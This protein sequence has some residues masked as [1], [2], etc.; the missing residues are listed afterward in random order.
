MKKWFFY[1]IKYDLKKQRHI[2]KSLKIVKMQLFQNNSEY[3][4]NSMQNT[5]GYF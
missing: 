1:H 4:Y 5:P 3:V 2:V